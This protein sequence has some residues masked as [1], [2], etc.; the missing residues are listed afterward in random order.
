[1][2]QQNHLSVAGCICSTLLRV[3]FSTCFDSPKKNQWYLVLLDVG[4]G[5]GAGEQ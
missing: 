4:P 5:G 2:L 1:M 3:A